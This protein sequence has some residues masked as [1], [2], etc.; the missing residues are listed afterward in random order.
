MVYKTGSRKG[1]S[2]VELLVVIAIIAVL[3]GLL[4]PAIQK[5]RH[6]A[7]RMVSVNNLRQITLA[8]ANYS[9]SH[10]DKLPALSGRTKDGRRAV[11]VDILPFLEQESVFKIVTGLISEEEL[12]ILQKNPPPLAIP[13]YQNPL[14]FTELGFNSP[15]RVTPVTSYACN[16]QVFNGAP[17]LRRVRDGLSNTMLF[18]EHYRRCGEVRF[19]YIGGS[20]GTRISGNCNRPSFADSGLRRTDPDCGDFYPI[21]KGFPPVS[22]ASSN[23]TFQSI[24]S[25]RECD[26][27]LLNA[28]SLNGLQS[29]MA[30]GSIRVFASTVSPAVFWGSITPAGGEVVSSWE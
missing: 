23:V 19:T 9:N 27:R 6:T 12:K 2:L 13:V 29:T 11:F 10:S 26:P 8:T 3:I 18:S 7:L 15:T 28:T 21:T 22:A 20:F 25:E 30:D 14:D 5:V 16:A 17:S 24:P 4:L 1:F